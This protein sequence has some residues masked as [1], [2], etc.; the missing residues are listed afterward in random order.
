MKMLRNTDKKN[1]DN[2]KTIIIKYKYYKELK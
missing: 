2:K 1:N